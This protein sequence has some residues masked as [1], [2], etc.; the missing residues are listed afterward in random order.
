MTFT[1]TIIG[2]GVATAVARGAAQALSEA[3][4]RETHHRW[5]SSVADPLPHCRPSSSAA[6]GRDDVRERPVSMDLYDSNGSE[7]VHEELA[8]EP[9]PCA[10]STLRSRP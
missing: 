5:T 2:E 7:A 1:R 8:D 10:C 6:H 9:K 4:R 3:L